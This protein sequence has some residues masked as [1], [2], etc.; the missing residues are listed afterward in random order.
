MK[1]PRTKFDKFRSR[2]KN[3]PIFAS[4]MVLGM[5][6]IALSTFTDAAKNL[7]GLIIKET[8]PNINGEWTAEV[9]YPW[10]KASYFETFSFNGKGNEVHGVASY[11]ENKQVILEGKIIEEGRIEFKTKTREYSPDWDNNNI[12]LATHHYSGRIL[13]NEIKFVMETYG[14]FSSDS[15]I[16]IIAKKAPNKAN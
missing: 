16:E 3:N 14:G 11:L 2:I 5:I 12:K 1:E 15:P 10:K 4:L 13:G 7:L 9:I 6:I 8:R